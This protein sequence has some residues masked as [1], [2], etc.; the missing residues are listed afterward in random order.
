MVSRFTALGGIAK[1]RRMQKSTA[2]GLVGTTTVFF[3]TVLFIA[4]STVISRPN[5]ESQA[6]AGA[7]ENVKS[8]LDAPRPE[9][10][11]P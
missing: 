11:A 6:L 3:G 5:K 9:D 2:L 10:I 1:M 4:L 7:R 8:A